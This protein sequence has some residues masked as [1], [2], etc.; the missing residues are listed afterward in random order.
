M[1]DIEELRKSGS[2]HRRVGGQ[3]VLLDD[4]IALDILWTC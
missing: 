1:D 3:R 4:L 2:V